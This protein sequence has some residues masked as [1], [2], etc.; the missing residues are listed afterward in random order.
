MVMVGNDELRGGERRVELHGGSGNDKLVGG[1]DV[2]DD[3][4]FG[5]KG[6][7]TLTGRDGADSFNCGPGT[8]TITDSDAAGG[9]T[10]TA[11]CENFLYDVSIL[12]ENN[13]TIGTLSTLSDETVENFPSIE[14]D[15]AS[16]LPTATL[17]TIATTT[18]S[19][20]NETETTT[21]SDEQE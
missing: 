16:G 12:N 4:L 20:S 17:P 14:E 21:A 11:D 10:K 3:E 9:D 1:F 15:A 13:P 7:D 18:T 8:D 5:G 2:N 6:D 19:T